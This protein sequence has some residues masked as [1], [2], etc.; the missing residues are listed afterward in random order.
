MSNQYLRIYLND[1]LAGAV[2]GVE[3]AKR[4]A[5]N[6]KGT[7][8]FDE[9]ETLRTD[10]QED[11]DRL[12]KL[13]NQ[14]DIPQN[15][16]KPPVSWI[17]EKIGRLKFNGRLTGYSELSRVVELEALALGVE[18]KSGLWTALKKF[19]QLRDRIGES[20]LDSMLNRARDQRDRIEGLRLRAV[21]IVASSG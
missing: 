3:L 11:R 16:V 21:D 13:M 6:N 8:F 10:I 7:E 5:G 20:W 19:A 17:A 2:A 14:L 4:V 12:M 1:H 15:P 9:L 18:G